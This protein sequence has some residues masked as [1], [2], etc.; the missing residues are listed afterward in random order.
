MRIILVLVIMMSAVTLR[1]QDKKVLDHDDYKKWR[2]IKGSEISGDGKFLLYRLDN[3][4]V[5]PELKIYNVD[6]KDYYEFQRSSNANFSYDSKH[7]FFMIKPAYDSLQEMKRRKIKEENMPKDTLGI[8]NLATANVTLI[9]DV[10]SYKI[11]LKGSGWLAYLLETAPK[12]TTKAD[13]TKAEVKVKKESKKNGH[14]LVLR[15]TATN[16]QD[17][18]SYVLNYQFSE[19]GSALLF[20]SSGDDSL[21]APGV[22]RYDLKVRE[23]QPMMRGKA[24]FKEMTISNDGE[25]VA[26]LAH[27]DTVENRLVENFNLYY[28]QTGNDSAQVI[29]DSSHVK[30]P[31]G[32]LLN[33]FKNVSFS[34]NGERLFF[35]LYPP[36]VQPDTTLLDNEKV[37]VEVWSW[38]DE[39]LQTQQEVQKEEERKRGYLAVYHVGDKQFVPLADETVPEIKMDENQ[40]ADYAIGYSNLPYGR[41]ITWEGFPP[42]YDIYSINLK[43]G[44]KLKVAEKVKGYP[45]ISTDG[46]Y[47]TWYSVK[48]TAYFAYNSD[49]QQTINL[50]QGIDAQIWDELHDTPDYPRPY[51][52]AGWT[53]NDQSILIYDRY[54]IWQVNPENPD[55]A[56]K[57]TS[58]RDVQVSYRYMHLDRD[59]RSI[60]QNEPLYLQAVNQENRGEAYFKLDWQ[61]NN[62]TPQKLLGGDY[63]LSYLSKARNDEQVYFTKETFTEFPD[64]LTSALDFNKVT[65]VSNANPQQDDYRWGTVEMT[66]WTSFDGKELDGMLIKPEGFDPSKKYPMMVYFYERMTD[67]FHNY[68]VPE[69]ER[70]IINFSFYA[71]RGYLIFIP[72]IPYKTGYPGESAYN[73][74]MPGVTSMINKGF[75]DEESIGV[76]GHSW[77]GYQVAYLVTRTNLFAAAESGAPVVNMFSAYG[78]I[79]WQTGLSRQFQYEHTQSR[80]GGTP[81]RYPLRYIENSPVFFLDKIETPLLI[82]HNDKDG[83]VPWYQGIEFFTGLRR[84]QKP[85]WML[86]YNNE[87]H[88]PLDYQLKFD[89]TKRLQQFF[90]HYLKDEPMPQW[91]KRGV[92]AVEKGINL[93]YEPVSG[94]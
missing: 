89:F 1:A 63:A 61:K 36:P 93:G 64:L 48:D 52:A 70:S 88:W 22:Y 13:T 35:H 23:L 53:E 58:G 66:Q 20:Q 31:S 43:S 30:M 83:H 75:V 60:I 34:E 47:L 55:A 68:Y 59:D 42:Y 44:E 49:K 32:W 19:D 14:R 80:I 82:M 45:G 91:M 29:V 67:R 51:G 26:F 85:A 41:F 28:W 25:Q 17:T 94:E 92:P 84:L 71:S 40:E 8:F 3:D 7:A 37:S 27:Q 90:D 69:P 33:E 15:K 46:N 76:Q 18:F 86:N 81:W 10:Q 62:A 21:F 57:L 12:D 79:R 50:S 39:Y 5:D 6:N 2:E 77:G 74:V 4:R 24:T 11:P 38:H 73:A 56:V 87:P 16:T 54:D 65:K 78:G 9:P 72:D